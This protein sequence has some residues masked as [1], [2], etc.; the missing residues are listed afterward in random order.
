[1]TKLRW[2]LTVDAVE[3]EVV[4]TDHVARSTPSAF[5]PAKGQLTGPNPTDRGNKGSK[6]HLFVDRRGLPL[7][8]GIPAANLHDSQALIP[9]V[10]GIPPIRSRRGPRRRR[11][12]KLHGA[13]PGAAANVTP[14]RL[15]ARPC[16][17]SACLPRTASPEQV[18]DGSD[19]T[20]SLT[21]S[22]HES[23]SWVPA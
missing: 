21:A 1:M 19:Q 5:G 11:P 7:S 18:V 20:V 6:I 13:T 10:R 12:G 4:W 16:Q 2:G 8:I 14:T 17:R 15:Q 22:V 9:Q 23:L 3:E